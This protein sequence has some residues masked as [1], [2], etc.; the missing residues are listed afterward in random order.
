MIIDR[1]VFPE[2]YGGFAETCPNA[3]DRIYG[4]AV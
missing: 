4:N 1:S 2:P 3:I